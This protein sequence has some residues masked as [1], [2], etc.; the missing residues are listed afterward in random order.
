MS[1]SEVPVNIHDANLQPQHAALVYL[2]QRGCSQHR[3]V[4]LPVS[5]RLDT[6]KSLPP[7]DATT[8]LFPEQAR[9]RSTIIGMM[10][11]LSA[12]CKYH[13]TRGGGQLTRWS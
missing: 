13:C 10:T 5:N 7:V 12:I 8:C 11:A 1:M 2:L 3:R 6:R 9:K 4:D